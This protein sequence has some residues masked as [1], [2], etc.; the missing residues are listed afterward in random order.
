MCT[1]DLH[2]VARQK[3]YLKVELSP[4]LF[5]ASHLKMMKNAF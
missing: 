2:R 5:N 1:T 4:I 3:N